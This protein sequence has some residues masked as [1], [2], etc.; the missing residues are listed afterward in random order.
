MIEVK[1][2]IIIYSIPIPSANGAINK[3]PVRTV[4]DLGKSL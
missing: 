1:I 2:D 4:A 3:I